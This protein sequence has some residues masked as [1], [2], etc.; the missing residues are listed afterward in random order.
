[1]RRAGCEERHLVGEVAVDGRATNPGPLGD[2]ADRGPRGP[3]RPVE[4]DGALGD[5]PAGLGL[6]LGAAAFAVAA[7]FVGH[8][9]P[10]N[11]AHGSAVCYEFARHYCLIKGENQRWRQRRRGRWARAT[12]G[13]DSWG[14]SAFGS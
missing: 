3:E 4:L 12:A 2:G 10:L 11:I 7:L 5:A 13:W 9:C 1:M 14:A 6:V 8:S